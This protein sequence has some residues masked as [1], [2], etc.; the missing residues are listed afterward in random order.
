MSK[1]LG[2]RARVLIADDEPEIRNVLYDLL[3]PAYDCAAVGSAEEA[4]AR[5]SERG[6]D[7][8]ISDIMMGGMSGLEM[9]PRVLERSPDTVVIMISGVQTVE[10]AIHALRAGAFDYV[11]K[12]FDLQHVEAAVNRA[13]E[14]HSLR[15]EKRR[16]ETYLEEM[17]EQRTSELNRA[18]GSLGDAYR[19]TLKSLTAALEARDSETHGHSERVVNFSLRLGRELGLEANLERAQE[20]IYEAAQAG[21]PLNEEAR[22]FALALGLA[23]VA[24]AATRQQHES[25]EASLME[26]L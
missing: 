18:L 17:V 4:L 16:Y 1:T 13:L 21:A 26:G 11:M 14:H 24:L 3:S 20:I 22:D 7:L 8:V 9:I 12:P 19:S 6:Y 25:E 5:L 23:P 2:G 15:V 10:S